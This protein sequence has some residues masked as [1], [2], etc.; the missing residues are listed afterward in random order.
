MAKF[1]R[2]RA[3][4]ALSPVK[5][6]S[7]PTA[8]T[9]EGAP[10]YDRD[11]KSKLFLLAVANM[12][13]E[14]TFYEGAEDRDTRFRILVGEVAVQ[15]ID[16]LTRM[17]GWLR[18]EV[19]MRSASVVAA[20][21]GVRARL[22]ASLHGDNRRLID[23]ALG[24]ADEPGELLAYW[25][26]RY[27]RALPQPVK[28]GVADAV[29]RLYDER[30]LIKYDTGAFRF[31]DVVELTHPAPVTPRQGDLFRHAID[32]RH[33]RDQEI[34][35]SLEVLRARAELLALPKDERRALLDRPDAPQI[36]KAAGMTWESLAGWLQG[37]LTARFWEAIIPSMGLLALI[38]NLRNFDRA[39]ISDRAAEQVAA[40]LSDAKS[41]RRSRVLPMRFLAAYREAPSLRWAWPLQR[42]L[43]ASL[44]NVPRLPGRTLVL[45]DR[46]GS[47]F[48]PMSRHSK[49]TQADAAALFGTA[50]ALRAEQADLVE[51]GTDHRR[52]R[53]RRGES[54]LS[55]I[56][57][58]GELGG[59]NTAAAVRAHY[60]RH[61]RVIIVTDEQV[62]GGPN[63]ADPTRAVPDRVPVYT[64]N[65]AG[66]RAGHGPSGTGTRHTF[67][68][69]S[70]AAFAMIPL[71]ERGQAADWPF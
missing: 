2:A 5:T 44:A 45:V 24:R 4:G 53:F 60:H 46:S 29:R 21:E 63:G 30:S 52:V 43:D 15:D 25:H 11:T 41:V 32:R 55:V 16:W 62:W 39:G 48:W 6:T 68:G 70:D 54:V 57:R 37:P 50:L 64:W 71:I 26:A 34:P 3:K 69:L 23:V 13:G 7:R 40:R 10:G 20:A 9:Y 61:D 35:A 59:T 51:F 1:N 27:G 47:M 33:G 28:R 14:H 65:L 36:L 67:G 66:Y 42:A 58:F 49:L 56:E 8:C 18:N 17:V 31:G 19:G 38:R 12:V 22:D